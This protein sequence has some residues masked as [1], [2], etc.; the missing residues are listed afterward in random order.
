MASAN[1]AEG[2]KGDEPQG[3]AAARQPA[4]SGG[5]TATRPSSRRCPKGRKIKR[6]PSRVYGDR[7]GSAGWRTCSSSTSASTATSSRAATPPLFH[8]S[9]ETVKTPGGGACSARPRR[10][11]SRM[12][13]PGGSAARWKVWGDAA[14]GDELQARG[15]PAAAQRRL[16]GPL[17]RERR[18]S[19]DILAN[20]VQDVVAHH[21]R[22]PHLLRR[23]DTRRAPRHP[24]LRG[25]AEFVGGSTTSR[26]NQGVDRAHPIRPPPRRSQLAQPAA[27]FLRFRQT[28][29]GVDRAPTQT[30][31]FCEFKA[32][33]RHKA[34]RIQFTP[35]TI[36][37][38]RV[39]S[40]AEVAAARLELAAPARRLASPPWTS[41]SA[42]SSATSSPR[43]ATSAS[44]RPAR[45]SSASG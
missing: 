28:T 36:A 21:R 7:R 30:R 29:Y 1:A 17:R 3:R 5:P 20:G 10:A 12:G 40:R 44:A 35:R 16:L 23:P 8:P 45:R 31:T 33:P 34:A 19:G 32:V 37:K 2:I 6:D 26:G 27:R 22:H 13:S 42:T 18:R 41:S 39:G 15:R 14:H 11:G 25:L 9:P 24:A 4:R 43:S 38:F